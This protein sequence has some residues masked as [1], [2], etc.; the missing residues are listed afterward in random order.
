M[1]EHILEQRRMEPLLGASKQSAKAAKM[2]AIAAIIS[3]IIALFSLFF[4]FY[5]VIEKEPKQ[6]TNTQERSIN[7]NNK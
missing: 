6:I 4:S 5:N 2:A 3:A 7:R 1:A